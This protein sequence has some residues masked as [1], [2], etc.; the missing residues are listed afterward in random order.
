MKTY[1]TADQLANETADQLANELI[2]AGS[3][4]PNKEYAHLH[5]IIDTYIRGGSPLI[6]H[7]LAIKLINDTTGRR[8]KNPYRPFKALG[9]KKSKRIRVNLPPLFWEQRQVFGLPISSTH[10]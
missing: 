7:Y 2:E 4:L 1:P 6:G 9:K 10:Q 5:F 3:D 8:L